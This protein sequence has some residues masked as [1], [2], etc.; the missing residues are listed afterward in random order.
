M[1]KENRIKIGDL[2]AAK[3]FEQSIVR[4][5]AGTVSYWSPEMVEFESTP[6]ITITTST[7]IWFF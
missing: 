3:N 4:T 5:A 7:D 1:L 6:N 2:G